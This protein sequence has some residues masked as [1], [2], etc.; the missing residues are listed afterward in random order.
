MIHNLVFDMGNVLLRFDP[1]ALLA[2][3]CGSADDRQ[4]LMRTVFASLEWAQMDR[5]V[6]TEQE[7]LSRFYAKLPPRLHDTAA[8]LTLHWEDYAAP[9][10]G[11]EALCRSLKAHGC[12][13]YLLSN[14]SSRQPEYWTR[15]PCHALFDGTVISAEW[16]CIKPQPEL[17]SILLNKYCLRAEECLFVDDFPPNADGATRVGMEAFVFHGDAEELRAELVRRHIL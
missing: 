14:T 7:A 10:E 5:G 8:L 1:Q 2:Q 6:L 9:V 17:Y 16:K 15:L 11:M 3:V 4:L 12:S 13:L